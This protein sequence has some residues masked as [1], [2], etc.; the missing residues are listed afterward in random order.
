MGVFTWEPQAGELSTVI[1]SS[2]GCTSLLLIVIGGCTCHESQAPA[3]TVSLNALAPSA[4]EAAV[5]PK[6]G[7][8]HAVVRRQ[9]YRFEFGTCAAEI[10]PTDGGRILEFSLGGRSVIVPSSESPEA[11]ASS[12]WP[13]P[14]SAWTWPP[15]VEFDKLPWTVS[16]E[17]KA[18]KL[19]SATAEKLDL[20]AQQLLMAVPEHNALSSRISNYQSC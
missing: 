5:I 2:R 14:Q 11:Y 6:D 17:G 15:P 12:F 3:I 16:L 19:T 1:P 13:S 7:T 20:S 8:P 18:L 9:N 10:D 4:N